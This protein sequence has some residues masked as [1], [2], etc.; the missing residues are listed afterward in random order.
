MHTLKLLNKAC[1]L[2]ISLASWHAALRRAQASVLCQALCWHPGKLPLGV[3]KHLWCCA[4][5]LQ[6]ALL[7]DSKSLLLFSSWHGTLTITKKNLK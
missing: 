1:D 4:R 6:Q 7:L 3:P 2:S 5:S